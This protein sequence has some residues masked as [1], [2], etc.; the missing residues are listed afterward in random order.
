MHLLHG[1][2][3]P[4]FHRRGYVAI[5]N[6]DGVHRGHQ[7][8]IGLLVRLAHD[9]GVPAV[10]FT[11]DPHPTSILRP[12]KNPQSLSTVEHK[13]E[14]LGKHGVDCVIAYPTDRA[15]L[16]LTA[17]AFFEQIVLKEF[18]AIGLVEGP[19]FRFGR[20]RAGDITTLKQ[21]C[22]DSGLTLD[23]VEPVEYG[24]EMVSSSVVRSRIADGRISEAIEQLGHA[25]RIRPASWRSRDCW[26]GTIVSASNRTVRF[27]SKSP[28]CCDC[29]WKVR[30]AEVS[31]RSSWVGVPLVEKTASTMSCWSARHAIP[32]GMRLS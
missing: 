6:F 32:W 20:D 3:E 5:G 9:K 31:E 24:E 12:D 13:A 29:G 8:M 28:V 7:R 22:D 21:L 10:V 30:S 14:L 1:F 19:N 2:D 26:A 25:Y 16:D 4:A 11:F 18:Q 23:V 27:S 17:E 15:L